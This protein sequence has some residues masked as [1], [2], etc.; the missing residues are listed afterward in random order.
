MEII[1]GSDFEI[2]KPVAVTIG[3]FETIHVGHQI[4]IQHTEQYRKKGY[5]PVLFTFDTHPLEQFGNKD[6]RYV[7]S[8]SEKEMI[9]STYNLDYIIEYPFSETLI[10]MTPRQFFEDI[11][12]KKINSR[13]IVVGE[14]FRFGHKRSGD[15]VLLE[16]MTDEYNINL[17][18]VSRRCIDNSKIS[19]SSIRDVIKNG[20]MELAAEMLGRPYCVYGEVVHGRQ[21]GRTIGMPTINVYPKDDKLLPPRGVYSSKV[22]LSGKDYLAVTNIGYKPTVKGDKKIN[23]ESYIFDFDKNVYGENVCI[24]LLHFQRPEKKFE[25][26]DKLREQMDHDK[27]QAYKNL[28]R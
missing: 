1:H 14:D 18:V 22:Y 13:A 6:T 3:K 28:R 21:L 23:I 15:V 19:S 5:S 27:K 11:L 12:I 25:S 2:K 8:N 17:D 20:N 10:N 16:Q 7:Y 24:E 9:L 4:L 26:I